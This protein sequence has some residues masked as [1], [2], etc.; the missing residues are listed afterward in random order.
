M[1]ECRRTLARI[2]NHKHSRSACLARAVLHSIVHAGLHMGM[3]R[4]RDGY[5]N[6]GVPTLEQPP[7]RRARCR[8][9]P[10][11]LYIVLEHRM[12]MAFAVR[13]QVDVRRSMLSLCR[14]LSIRSSRTCFSR[15]RQTSA[16]SQERSSGPRPPGA[17]A[18]WTSLRPHRTVHFHPPSSVD[19]HLRKNPVRG[20]PISI[21]TG[22]EGENRQL[23][24]SR[25]LPAARN[26]PGRSRGGNGGIS[27]RMNGEKNNSHPII[28]RPIA[29]MAILVGQARQKFIGRRKTRDGTQA[30]DKP[31][32]AN[33]NQ[34]E[35]T[36]P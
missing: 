32:Q 15:A 11:V 17:G 2:G 27:V 25:Y 19:W 9:P 28:A 35:P 14:M 20:R 36:Q 16:L 29:A 12:V 13:F 31:I 3:A 18:C 21:A 26:L 8:V 33:P 7:I 34:P 30:T 24:T 22:I 5:F 1:H 4:M 6:C 10:G 23:R